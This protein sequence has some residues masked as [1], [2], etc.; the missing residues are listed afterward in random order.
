MYFSEAVTKNIMGVPNNF[1]SESPYGSKILLGIC[2]KQGIYQGI[3]VS[4][5]KRSLQHYMQLERFGKHPD[6]L[7]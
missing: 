2:L 4:S 7:H 6:V 1:K 3:K 5:I